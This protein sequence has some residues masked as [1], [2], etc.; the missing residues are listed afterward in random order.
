L[1]SKA[2]TSLKILRQNIINGTLNFLLKLRQGGFWENLEK[3]E[4]KSNHIW[5]SKEE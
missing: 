5:R 4:E 2:Y 1:L 3:K